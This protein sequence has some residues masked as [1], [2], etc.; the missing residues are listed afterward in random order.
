MKYI[1]AART[2]ANI[3]REVL[4]AGAV[5]SVLTY[6]YTELKREHNVRMSI[7]RENR[8]QLQVDENY[9]DM[10]QAEIVRLLESSHINK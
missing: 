6:G 8:E 1:T 5:A 3:I 9:K 2:A 7:E 4:Y 10:E